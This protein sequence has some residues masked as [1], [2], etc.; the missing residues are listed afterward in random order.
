MRNLGHQVVG[1]MHVFDGSLELIA[2]ALQFSTP[3]Q[4]RQRY[5]KP[6]QRLLF[7]DWLDSDAGTAREI[8]HCA[9]ATRARGF[10][11]A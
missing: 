3:A 11:I 1:L 10:G 6:E 7:G 2:V 8:D 5:R 4:T 9:D